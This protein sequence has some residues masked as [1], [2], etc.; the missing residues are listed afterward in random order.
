MEIGLTQRAEFKDHQGGIKE[1]RVHPSGRLFFARSDE[2]LILYDLSTERKLHGYYSSTGYE[3]AMF[4]P[5]GRSLVYMSDERLHYWDLEKWREFMSIPGEI[6]ELRDKDAH[7][8]V[9]LKADGTN[10]GTI[11]FRKLEADEN[12]P[13]EFVIGSH[14]NYIEYVCFHPSGKILASGSADKTL[15]FWDVIGRKQI[16]VFKV[17]SDFVTAIAFSP[18][19]KT[20]I[21]GDYSGVLKIWNL[22]IKDGE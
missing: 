2:M 13:P 6:F 18:D 4:D 21:T 14:D 19:G 3:A 5:G 22:E 10:E 20:A 8:G 7:V 16:S 17:H 11:E 9:G 15:R 12:D 1:I